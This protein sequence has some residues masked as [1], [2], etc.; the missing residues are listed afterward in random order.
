MS[1][2]NAMSWAGTNEDSSPACPYMTQLFLFWPSWGTGTNSMR[3]MDRRTGLRLERR[4]L[5]KLLFRHKVETHDLWTWS[6]EWGYADIP[7]QRNPW[8]GPRSNHTRYGAAIITLFGRRNTG[9][10]YW[11]WGK[12]RGWKLYSRFFGAQEVRSSRAEICDS[13]GV[14]FSRFSALK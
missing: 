2:T 14:P 1:L 7:T 4:F 5:F 3:V 10:D 12:T 6:E 13:I 8:A 11:W 9:T